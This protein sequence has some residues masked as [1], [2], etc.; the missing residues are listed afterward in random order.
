MKLNWLHIALILLLI[1]VTIVAAVGYFKVEQIN[2]KWEAET[3]ELQEKAENKAKE[4]EQILGQLHAE[5]KSRI[6]AEEEVAELRQKWKN[7][8]PLAAIKTVEECKEQT[9]QTDI[10]VEKQAETIDIM[11]ITEKALLDAYAKK[12]EEARYWK[13]SDGIKTQVIKKMQKQ[14]RKEKVKKVFI[15]IGGTVFGAGVGI[16]VGAALR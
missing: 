16:G 13:E 15:G 14:Q 5:A 1:G 2:A 8:K 3:N 10:L 6:A 9:T 4:A 11:K 12:D 7:R